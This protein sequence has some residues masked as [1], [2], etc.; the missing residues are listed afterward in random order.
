MGKRTTAIVATVYGDEALRQKLQ[1]IA[2]AK[3]R[4]MTAVLRDYIEAEYAKL[5]SGSQ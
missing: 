3:N 2:E 4:P 1:A 5:Q